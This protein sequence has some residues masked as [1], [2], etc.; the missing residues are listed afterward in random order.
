MSCQLVCYEDT[1]P[2]DDPT[3]IVDADTLL[4]QAVSQAGAQQWNFTQAKM[5]RLSQRRDKQ[6][7]YTGPVTDSPRLTTQAM[8]YFLQVTNPLNFNGEA[9]G[10]DT[11]QAGSVF[12]DWQVQFQTPQINPTALPSRVLTPTVPFVLNNGDL[13]P[14]GKY[15][16]CP[17]IGIVNPDLEHEA[18][19]DAVNSGSGLSIVVWRN[20]QDSNHIVTTGMITCPEQMAF[21]TVYGGEQALAYAV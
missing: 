14:A 19:L 18:T 13:L 17:K 9:I 7:Y 3:K 8:V 4:R 1:D 10:A 11:I 15:V 21:R 12:I 5:T 6:Q 2:S 16:V 20:D